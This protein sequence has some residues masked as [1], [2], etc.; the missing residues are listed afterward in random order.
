MTEYIKISENCIL[1][2]EYEGEGTGAPM[3]DLTVIRDGR[4]VRPRKQ[5][6]LFIF[7]LVEARKKKKDGFFRRDEVIQRV[8]ADSYLPG[9]VAESLKKVVQEAGKI[10]GKAAVESDRGRAFRLA[11]EIMVSGGEGGRTVPGAFSLPIADDLPEHPLYRLPETGEKRILV[12]SAPPGYGKTVLSLQYGRG[13]MNKGTVGKVILI[14]CLSTGSIYR[15]LGLPAIGSGEDYGGAQTAE[16]LRQIMSSEAEIQ[17]VAGK[18]VLVILDNYR[19]G[20]VGTETAAEAA[21]KALREAMSASSGLHAVIDTWL[22]PSLT[23]FSEDEAEHMVL[24]GLD[25]ADEGSAQAA[26]EILSSEGGYPFTEDDA[27]EILRLSGASRVSP[28]ELLSVRIGVNMKYAASPGAGADW[29]TLYR[30]GAEN[31][32]SS[33]YS[34]EKAVGALLKEKDGEAGLFADILRVA[35]V[36]GMDSFEPDLMLLCLRQTER[37]AGLGRGA[38]DEALSRLRKK[39]GLFTELSEGRLRLLHC[40]RRPVL[41]CMSGT[42]LSEAFGAVCGAL[43][44]LLDC[45]IYYSAPELQKVFALSR[46]VDG[47]IS[48][49]PAL[50]SSAVDILCHT[51]WYYTYWE[52]DSAAAE[53]YYEI[54]AKAVPQSPEQVFIK[55]L[56]MCDRLF[57]KIKTAGAAPSEVSEVFFAVSSAAEGLGPYREMLL[58]RLY[59]VTMEH[60]IPRIGSGERPGG[61][62]LE[63]LARASSAI[64]PE[65]CLK[66]A[67]GLGD[68]PA[69]RGRYAFLMEHAAALAVLRARAAS[70]AGIGESRDRV[71]EVC[72]PFLNVRGSGLSADYLS[73]VRKMG[74]LAALFGQKAFVPES[75]ELLFARLR[76]SLGVAW[77]EG[78]DSPEDLVRALNCFKEAL[79]VFEPDSFECFNCEINVQTVF[80]LVGLGLCCERAGYETVREP[81]GRLTAYFSSYVSER[82]GLGSMGLR[83]ENDAQRDTLACFSVSSSILAGIPER[84]ASKGPEARSSYSDL[85]ADVGQNTA[86]LAI[87][88]ASCFKGEG[89]EKGVKRWVE[90]GTAAIEAALSDAEAKGQS[91]RIR[92]FSRYAASLYLERGDAEKAM[93]MIDRSLAMTDRSDVSMYCLALEVKCRVL[94]SDAFSYEERRAFLDLLP[95]DVMSRAPSSIRERLGKAAERLSS[96]INVDFVHVI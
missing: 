50:A 66:A 85:M 13:L 29:R 7:A 45:G 75:E 24:E 38:V 11:N 87:A 16:K 60:L 54:I 5:V 25:L 46:Y 19:C 95:R 21:G 39:T 86:L 52:R 36:L 34:P 91:L 73:S 55:A 62:D 14:D 40:Y 49:A 57:L 72:S 26:L 71:L 1:K 81:L 12:I 35:A 8:W 18:G 63:D 69:L 17:A 56:A 33:P 74:S 42:E 83:A 96:R 2:I 64:Y 51:A 20:G 30:A 79:A 93:A 28:A 53:K 22:E 32:R 94:E 58:A 59:L 47:M 88:A 41:S 6:R 43:R 90:R 3:S 31:F 68:T 76:N 48:A 15:S 80:R 82:Y 65:G 77:F 78:D 89:S 44:S 70:L 23:G 67:S 10:L 4:E 61:M 84:L 92:T 9:D 27:R 37:Y